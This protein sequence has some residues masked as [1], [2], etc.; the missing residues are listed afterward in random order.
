MEEGGRGIFAE[1]RPRSPSLTVSGPTAPAAAVSEL[2]H[3]LGE[4]DESA[5]AS[6]YFGPRLAP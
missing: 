3:S 2:T 1:L 5:D 6:G 4:A